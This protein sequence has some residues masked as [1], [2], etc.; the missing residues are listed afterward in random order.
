MAFL[1]VWLFGFSVLWGL[2]PDLGSIL[3][4]SP[5]FK[6]VLIG[7]PAWTKRAPLAIPFAL[8]LSPVL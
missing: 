2:I 6:H 4:A 8:P 3:T 7:E 5:R 1:F